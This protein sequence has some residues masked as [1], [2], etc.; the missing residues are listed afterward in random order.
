MNLIDTHVHLWDP[1]HFRMAWL[2]G[3]PD[4]ADRYLPVDLHEHARPH[5]VDAFVYAEVDVAPAYALMEVRWVERLAYADPRLQGIIAHAPVEYGAQLKAYLD[6]LVAISSRVRGVRRLIQANRTPGFCIGERFVAGVRMLAQYG[7]SF[8]ICI[9]AD[10]LPD[11]IEL[12]R[13]CP[14]VH[15]VLDHIGKA[16]IANKVQHP[17]KRHIRDMARMPNVVC[18]VSGMVTEADRVKWKPRDLK[19]YVN[20]VIEQFGEDRVMY[21]GDWPVCLLAS[22]YA[23]WVDTLDELTRDMSDDARAKLFRENARRVYRIRG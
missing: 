3:V 16:D 6:E 18:K 15:F 21:G 5:T 7:L 19:P 4:I 8:D 13:R 22:P 23:R 2:D 14:E 9:T 12:V 17:W 11:A 10:Q 1:E 20:H